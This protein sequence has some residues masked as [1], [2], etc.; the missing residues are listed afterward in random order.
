MQ[1]THEDN[2]EQLETVRNQ[3]AQLDRK[4]QNNEKSSLQC[5]IVV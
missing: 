3:E 1:T 5:D 4:S 2:A